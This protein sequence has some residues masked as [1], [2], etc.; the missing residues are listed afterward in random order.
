[1]MAFLTTTP[2]HL[3]W[4]STRGGLCGVR[5][6]RTRLVQRRVRCALD[7]ETSESTELQATDSA[8][9][10]T[11]ISAT[12]KLVSASVSSTTS[13][14]SSGSGVPFEVRGFSL[15]NIGLLAGLG[16]TIVS[17]YSFFGSSGTAG[18][19]S[20]GFV[21]GVPIAL[22]GAALKYAELKPVPLKTDTL[23]AKARE[24]KST[25]TLRQVVKD[26]TRH[27]Y[28]DE[29][30]LQPAL[31]ALGLIARGQPCPKLISA[32]ERL[33]EDEY[34]LELD[35]VSMHTPYK[36][37]KEQISKYEQFFG[38]G[39]AAETIKVS[40]EERIVRMRLISR[41]GGSSS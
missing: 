22:V 29:S 20:L 39:I 32:S 10:S 17:F 12:E 3:G 1:M 41:D 9:K 19:T 6:G 5:Q 24:T 14:S 7:S 40:E 33:V 15:G 36:R 2:V 18:A 30:H 28:G 34:V 13:T 25:D 26:I 37:W 27:R 11:D 4:S 16:I 31:S 38:P 8:V 21:Y 35:F 23:T